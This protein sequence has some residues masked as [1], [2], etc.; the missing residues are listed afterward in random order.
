MAAGHA[1]F[2]D[3][4]PEPHQRR[5]QLP[6]A[7]RALLPARRR[8]DERGRPV[9]P[10][11]RGGHGAGGPRQ[12]RARLRGHHRRLPARGDVGLGGGR[13]RCPHHAAAADDGQGRA[14]QGALG[15]PHRLGRHH[16]ADPAAEHRLRGLRRGR[17][18]LDLQALPG[19]HR[20]RPDARRL[21][22]GHLVVVG[23][24]GRHRLAAAP[25]VQG[26][27]GRRPPGGLGPGAAGHHHL[28]PQ[29]RRLHAHR[30]RR[31]R[32]RVRTF[33]LHRDLP[34]AE[35]EPALRRLRRRRPHHL[36]GDAAGG[37][38]GGQCLADHGGQHPGP[39]GHPAAAA[40]R[41]PDAA[42]GRHH[43][44]GDDCRHRAR[45]GA[46]HP[47]PHPGAD[48]IGQRRR[49]RPRLLRRALH[50]QQRHRPHHTAGGG[51]AQHGGRCGQG[52]HGRGDPRRGALHDRPAHPDVP[53]G[54]VP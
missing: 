28:R 4:G 32:R 50:D 13:C 31:R 3:P 20:A 12:G 22:L 41:Q 54:A 40:A 39:G 10:H 27:A 14:R 15:R 26:R 24:R 44:A 21:D 37:R 35:V 53:D 43:G 11:R 51:G 30:G 19:R 52:E 49:H 6:A 25:P 18:R 38:R 23:P 29:A 16:R 7:G 47:H 1:R 8:A 48:A 33:R 17:Q 36:G 46:H 34:R 45:H 2:A 42:D 9:A 5:R